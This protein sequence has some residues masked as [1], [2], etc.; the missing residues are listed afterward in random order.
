MAAPLTMGRVVKSP[1]LARP[2]PPLL[3]L[4]QQTLLRCPVLCTP[5]VLSRLHTVQL[6]VAASGVGRKTQL[7]L[8]H[9]LATKP[10]CWL[11]LGGGVRLR[12]RGAATQTATWSDMR[13]GMT[14]APMAGRRTTASMTTTMTPVRMMQ[15]SIMGGSLQSTE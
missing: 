2:G 7:L 12:L 1:S 8:I 3:G 11:P 15:W 4:T 5:Q 9:H 6:A 14:S 13:L 10:A